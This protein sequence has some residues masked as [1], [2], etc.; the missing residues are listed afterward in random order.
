MKT[1]P[2][3]A[4]GLPDSGAPSPDAGSLRERAYEQIAEMLAS[5]VLGPG[6]K[7][8]LRVAA[9]T[10]GMSIMPV[11]EAVSRLVADSALEVTRSR[12]VRVPVMTREQF[13][14]LTSVRVAVEGHAAAQA[15]TMVSPIDLRA[16]RD[17]EQAFRIEGLS[18]QPDLALTI[19]LNKQFHFAV[20]RA[21]RSAMLTKVIGGLWL[22]AG[23][24]ITLDL[25]GKPGRFASGSVA[26]HAAL[27]A[28]IEVGDADGARAALSRDIENAA[29]YIL[30][31]GGLPD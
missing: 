27:L 30:T 12:A 28:A 13:R 9:E 26:C 4:T 8:S 16:I 31:E 10:L 11:R 7:I 24:V 5:G 6:A 14:D 18:P 25:R 21:A 1:T 2:I 20:Y 3:V 17:A 15:A 23:P 19:A 29:S 22:K